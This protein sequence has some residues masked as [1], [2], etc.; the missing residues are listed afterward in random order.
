MNPSNITLSRPWLFLAIAALCCA[1]AFAKE[2][3]IQVFV[4]AGDENV[5]ENGIASRPGTLEAVVASNPKYSYLKNGNA[6]S[7]LEIGKAMA[8]AML[9]LTSQGG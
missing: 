6:A 9:K 5:F 8:E 2:K 1:H 3:P 4:L 7:Y